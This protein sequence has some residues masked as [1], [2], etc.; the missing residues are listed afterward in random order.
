MEDI[1]GGKQE[2]SLLTHVIVAEVHHVLEG[3]CQLLSSP[4]AKTEMADL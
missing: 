3:V 2:P 4:D 1:K